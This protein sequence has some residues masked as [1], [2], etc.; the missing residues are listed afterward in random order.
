ML[1][2]CCLHLG[3]GLWDRVHFCSP[4]LAEAPTPESLFTLAKALRGRVLGP[5]IDVS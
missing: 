4:D 2:L 3:L 5:S 1:S